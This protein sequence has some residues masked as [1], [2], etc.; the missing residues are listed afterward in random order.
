LI[1]DGAKNRVAILAQM[2]DEGGYKNNSNHLFSKRSEAQNS[3]NASLPR[4]EDVGGTD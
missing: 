1:R 2:N 4:I 3:L